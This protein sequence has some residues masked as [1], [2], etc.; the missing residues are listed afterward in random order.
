L[1]HNPKKSAIFAETAL[2]WQLFWQNWRD[3]RKNHRDSQG[4]GTSLLQHAT[5]LS[6]LAIEEN[7]QMAQIFAGLFCLF[8]KS[9]RLS[10]SSAEKLGQL[11]G[12]TQKP[13]YGVAEY[14]CF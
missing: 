4:C 11:T 5:I 13:F 1:F 12:L 9:P 7:P 14:T 8:F 3:F 10:A 6:F 2:L